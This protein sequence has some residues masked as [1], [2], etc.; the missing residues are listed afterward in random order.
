[1][2]S[3]GTANS[4]MLTA[5]YFHGHGV[6]SK[7]KCLQT[8]LVVELCDYQYFPEARLHT[9]EIFGGYC[10]ATLNIGLPFTTENF[11][12]GFNHLVAFVEGSIS[13]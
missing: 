12:H 4:V 10:W 13:R 8:Q 7:W 3:L 1:M 9:F 5:L 6:R 11:S 2:V